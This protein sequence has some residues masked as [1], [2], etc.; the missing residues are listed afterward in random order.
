MDIELSPS[1]TMSLYFSD[2]IDRFFYLI[3]SPGIQCGSLLSGILDY[4][5]VELEGEMT[6]KRSNRKQTLPY[7]F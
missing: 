6:N 3:T 1:N 5:H 2:T 4:A 7:G